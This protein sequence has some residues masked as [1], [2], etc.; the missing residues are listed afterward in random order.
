MTEEERL[1]MILEYLGDEFTH[2]ED[3]K[4]VTFIASFKQVEELLEA[5]YAEG[6]S[7]AYEGGL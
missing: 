1:K 2:W 6:R 7:Y 3:G 4:P 5:A